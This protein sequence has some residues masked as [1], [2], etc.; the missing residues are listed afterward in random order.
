MEVEVTALEHQRC[1]VD[2]AGTAGAPHLASGRGSGARPGGRSG[3][4]PAGGRPAAQVYQE[5]LVSGQTAMSNHD[6][7]AAKNAFDAA[8]RIKPLPPEMQS[9][10]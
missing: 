3:V 7:E 9:E 4:T 6:Y 1:H 8:Q 10:P 5:A 2:R